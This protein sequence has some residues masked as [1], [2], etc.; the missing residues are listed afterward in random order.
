MKYT[1]IDFPLTQEYEEMITKFIE[2]GFKS[3]RII[4]IDNIYYDL[5][6]LSIPVN[7]DCLNCEKVCDVN[8]CNGHPYPP[9]QE[10]LDYVKENYDEIFTDDNAGE[11]EDRAQLYERLLEK[12]FTVKFNNRMWPRGNVKRHEPMETFPVV[13]DNGC[14]FN[15]KCGNYHKC[16]IHA[17]ALTEGINPIAKKPIYCSLYPLCSVDLNDKEKFLFCILDEDIKFNMWGGVDQSKRPCFNKGLLTD[18]NRDYFKD[19]DYKPAL[20]AS[21]NSVSY[22]YGA[23]AATKSVLALQQYLNK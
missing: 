12:Q 16:M 20:L 14:I 7:M 15:V 1:M 10:S 19:E 4:K 13:P 11:P 8:C 23:D 5:K 9:Q 17:H 3:G 2:D 21:I 22:M 6:S 18:P